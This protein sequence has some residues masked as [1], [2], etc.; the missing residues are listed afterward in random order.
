MVFLKDAHI[1]LVVYFDEKAEDEGDEQFSTNSGSVPMNF[2]PDFW[3][4]RDEMQT[5]WPPFSNDFQIN[6]AIFERKKPTR[7]WQ[8]YKILK[9]RFDTGELLK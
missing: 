5:Y 2:V 3:I 6:N 7:T 4:D 8:M 1:W 9:I